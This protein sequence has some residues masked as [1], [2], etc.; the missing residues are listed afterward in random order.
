MTT[1]FTRTRQQ[2]PAAQRTE[3]TPLLLSN[4]LVMSWPA[5]S[6]IGRA[7]APATSPGRPESISHVTTHAKEG[8]G[9]QRAAT[10]HIPWFCCSKL[11]KSNTLW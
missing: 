10:H 3:M 4:Q 5:A 7:S 6:R 11:V 1:T 9:A 2:Q 8:K